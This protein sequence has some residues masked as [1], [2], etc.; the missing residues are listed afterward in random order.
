MACQHP[1]LPGWTR[2]RECNAEWLRDY[3]KVYRAMEVKAAKREGVEEMRSTVIEH[4]TRYPGIYF[5]A[6]AIVAI[7]RNLG[8]D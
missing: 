1:K 5:E 8:V 2:C 6:T 7:L 4:F 3:R